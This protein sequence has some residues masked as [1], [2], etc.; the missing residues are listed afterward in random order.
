MFGTVCALEDEELAELPVERVGDDLGVEDG[1][2]CV[3]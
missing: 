3:S 1:A 2:L